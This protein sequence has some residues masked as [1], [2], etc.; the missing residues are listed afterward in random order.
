M[1]RYT[2]VWDRKA[3]DQLAVIWMTATDP[4]SIQRAFREVDELLAVAPHQK[5]S[6]F[7]LAQLSPNSGEEL[8]ARISPLPEDLRQLRLG[9]VEAYFVVLEDDRKVIVYYAKLRGDSRGRLPPT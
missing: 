2:V 9:P 6:P 5:G 7:G 1:I 3:E 4:S 8:L